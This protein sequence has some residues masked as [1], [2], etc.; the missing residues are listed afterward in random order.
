[1]SSALQDHLYERRRHDAWS[2]PIPGTIEW[3]EYESFSFLNSVAQL[4]SSMVT[5]TSGYG[6]FPYLRRD[7]NIRIDDDLEDEYYE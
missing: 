2:W 5:S 1:M 7:S 4:K 6:A 3:F